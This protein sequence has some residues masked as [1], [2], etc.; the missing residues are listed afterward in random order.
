MAAPEFDSFAQSYDEILEGCL[1]GRRNSS[2]VEYFA[3]G[4]ALYLRRMMGD[5]FSGTILDYGCGHGRVARH[6][7]KA[8]PAAQIHGFDISTKT[9]QAADEALRQRVLLTSTE[10]DLLPTYDLIVV[11]GVLHHVQPRERVSFLAALHGRLAPTG[12]IVLFEHNPRNPLTRRIVAQCAIDCGAVLSAP[13]QTRAVME[14]AGLDPCGLDYIS[15]VPP[16][17]ARLRPVE[18]LLEW[19]PFGAQYVMIAVRQGSNPVQEA[20]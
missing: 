4:K 11:A 20:A 17:F 12:R 5:A 10:M 14:A 2:A 3:E 15:F 1:G 16:L 9:I 19:C 7:L 6:L 8:L 13:A 18:R